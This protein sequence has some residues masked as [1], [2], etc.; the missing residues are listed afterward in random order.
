MGTRITDVREWVDLTEATLDEKTYTVEN[1]RLIAA[2]WSKNG[3]AYPESVLEASAGLWGGVKAYAD[4]PSKSERKNRPERSIRDV[5]GIYEAPQYKDGNITARLKVIGEAR[6]WLWPLIEET[7][8]TGAGIVGLSINAVGKTAK[9]EHAGRRGVVVEAITHA[10]SVDVVTTPAAGGGFDNSTLMM[11]DDGWTEAVIADLSIDELRAA[12][13]D[14]LEALQNEWKTPRD[15]KALKEAKT[16]QTESAK[17]VEAARLE[18]R[19]VTDALE[20]AQKEVQRLKRIREVDR[21]IQK[22]T[23]PKVWKRAL[24]EELSESSPANW[25][26]ILERNERKAK[27]IKPMRVRVTGA[28]S[29]KE[30]TRKPAAIANRTIFGDLAVGDNESLK[31][32]QKRKKG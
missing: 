14:I 31:E 21:L 9:G 32:Y 20:V 1:A 2:G 17:L 13:P 4:H 27:A 29:L 3:R 26:R 24:F 7:V 8:N 25:D 10:N 18:T 19:T 12:R 30:A 6:T 28:G 23:L 16:S 22:T 15:N 11:A 5:V